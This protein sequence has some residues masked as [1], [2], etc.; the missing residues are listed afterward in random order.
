M[1]KV[2][3]YHKY[4][5]YNYEQ[6]D[7]NGFVMPFGDGPGGVDNALV[8]EQTYI[9]ILNYAKH[10][11]YISTPYLIPTYGLID[12][13]RNA[14]LRGVKVHLIVPGIPDKKMVY[15]V[16]ESNFAYLL[17]A[18]VKIYRYKP[19]FNHMKTILADETL[20][21]VGTINFDFRSLVHHFECGAVIYQDASLK[22]IEADFKEMLDASI[23]VPT[24]FK[25]RK[26][27]RQLCSL[28]K[29]ISPLL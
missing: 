21:M 11:V 24:D 8:G 2:S 19:G 3:D 7:N 6:Y 14:A 18:G 12:A 13:L 1:C 5:D 23:E 16:A 4:I 25:Q 22:D 28:I 27:S 26:S 29:I 15:K 17:E 20:A 9:N 10:E